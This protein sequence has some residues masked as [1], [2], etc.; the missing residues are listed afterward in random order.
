MKPKKYIVSATQTVNYYKEVEAENI[1]GA[2]KEAL[3][4][5]TII[6]ADN[7]N[8]YYNYWQP[9]K[10]DDKVQLTISDVEEIKED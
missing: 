9:I 4:D 3:T 5:E 2:K 7:P 1:Q 8:D 10:V 6:N